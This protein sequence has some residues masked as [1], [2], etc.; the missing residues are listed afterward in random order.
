K[1]FNVDTSSRNE[2]FYSNALTIGFTNI[3]MYFQM[4]LIA[5]AMLNPLWMAFLM[6]D[7]IL[8]VGITILLI[9]QLY[10]WL[11]P[12]RD[13]IAVCGDLAQERPFLSAVAQRQQKYHI[14]EVV[15]TD[16]GLEKVLQRIAPYPSVMAYDLPRD[17]SEHLVRYCYSTN[18]RLYLRPDVTDLAIHGA[19]SIQISDTQMLLL[20][21]EPPSVEQLAVK[22]AMDI[23]L[24]LLL[25]AL[26]SPIMLLCALLIKLDGG[27]VFYRQRRLTRH[28]SVFTLIKFR[29]MVV[30]AE[31]DGM[32]MCLTDDERITRAGRIMRPTRL[33]ELP[34][35]FNILKG[36]MSLVGPRPE[37]PEY[38]E[39][40]CLHMPDFALRL[41]VKA[42]L[43][44]YAQLFGKY[45]TS[46]RD[47]LNMD[48]LYITRF[49]ILRDLQLLAMTPKVMFMRESTEGYKEE[50]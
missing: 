46:P 44:G 35:L 50:K 11:F 41:A 43:T 25:L 23:A 18:K 5:R 4:C 1:A 34:Q 29:S 10:F 7:Q 19:S 31:A 13:I 49:S 21:N 27:P 14:T 20:K 36:D 22:R 15:T 39:E 33:D 45:N 42:G 8:F 2:L 47:K 32:K 38:A 9:K 30:N 26:F 48:L 24:S 28:G 6:L 12:M 16:V 37:R 17:I 40:H 3:I